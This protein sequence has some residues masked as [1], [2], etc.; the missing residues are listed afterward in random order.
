MKTKKKITSF[1]S[2]GCEPENEQVKT[3]LVNADEGDT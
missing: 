2:L 1:I 3:G